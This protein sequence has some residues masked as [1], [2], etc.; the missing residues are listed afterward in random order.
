MSIVSSSQE[1][2]L[3]EF[4]RFNHEFTEETF[5]NIGEEKEIDQ[6]NVTDYINRYLSEKG[7]VIDNLKGTACKSIRE[8][9][10]RLLLEKSNL[11]R[12]GIAVILD[13]TVKR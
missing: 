12:R 4:A 11:S 1:K 13:L 9:L 10:V 5:L 8:E 2:A 7:L 6:S 3:T